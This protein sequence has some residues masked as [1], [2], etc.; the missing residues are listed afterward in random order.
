[1]TPTTELVALAAPGAIPSALVA[2]GHYLSFMIGTACVTAERVTIKPAMT[3]EEEKRN[4]PMSVDLISWGVL[5]PALDR[6]EWMRD[7]FSDFDSSI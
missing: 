4:A 1:M 3:M 7:R 2:Y 5:R 6:V